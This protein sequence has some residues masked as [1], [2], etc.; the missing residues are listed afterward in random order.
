MADYYTVDSDKTQGWWYPRAPNPAWGRRQCLSWESASYRR[1]KKG[2]QVR[3]EHGEGTEV[4]N[5]PV[6]VDYREFRARSPWAG[7]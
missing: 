3:E 6:R 7:R 4:R 5:S 1:G 2:L